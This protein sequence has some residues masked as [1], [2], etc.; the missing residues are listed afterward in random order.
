[1]INFQT[2]K[3]KMQEPI[4]PNAE[5]MEKKKAEELMMK[6]IIYSFSFG[7]LRVNNIRVSKHLFFLGCEVAFLAGLIAAQDISYSSMWPSAIWMLYMLGG[8]FLV[9]RIKNSK[10]PEATMQGQI[11]SLIFKTIK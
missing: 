7:M 6:V 2:L 4:F 5:P 10:D 1:M 9:L 8:L 3:K 11:S